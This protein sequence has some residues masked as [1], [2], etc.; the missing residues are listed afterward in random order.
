MTNT[1]ALIELFGGT[2]RY[3]ALKGLFEDPEQAYSAKELAAKVG[4]SPGN[5]SDLLLRWTRQG[6]VTKTFVLKYPRY[7]A[8][9]DPAFQP[10]R[11][12]FQQGS[13]LVRELKTRL[14]EL[15]EGT[16]AAAA[17]F[18]SVASGKVTE[19]SD[20]DLLLLTEMSRVEAQALFKPVGRKLGRPVNVLAYA[21]EEWAAAV[22][23]GNPLAHE[24]LKSPLI[25]VKGDIGGTSQTKLSSEH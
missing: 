7:A 17:V 24:I 10:I 3:K 18:G 4:I 25:L 16:V 12:L 23:D 8:T 15:G 11:E 19:A 5:A 2:T 22:R 9:K 13:D 1:Q 21:P 14:G 20:V 6:L